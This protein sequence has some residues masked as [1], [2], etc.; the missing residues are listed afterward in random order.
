VAERGAL[1]GVPVHRAQ[2]RVDVDVG[3]GVDP[4]QHTGP[5]GQREQ[6]PAQHDG[7][8]SGMPEGELAQQDPQRRRGV[9]AAEDLPHPTGPDHVQVVD[10]VRSGGHPRD[11]RGQ[12]R[13]RVRCT[14][15]DPLIDEMDV[16]VEQAAQA[17]PLGQLQH[18]YQARGR[19]LCLRASQPQLIHGSRLRRAGPWPG[20]VE[21]TNRRLGRGCRC[22]R[23]PWSVAPC[24]ARGVAARR[25]CRPASARCRCW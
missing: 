9:D 3:L 24:P 19:A 20:L 8:L 6:V 11:D 21:Q 10:A 17:G 1:L 25:R 2:Q 16:L 5:L 4:V 7:E 14:G 22:R 13:R 23:S 12:L 15:R 18:R